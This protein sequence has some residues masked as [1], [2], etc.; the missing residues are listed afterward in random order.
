MEGS[1]IENFI[2]CRR[3]KLTD[4]FLGIQVRITSISHQTV[5]ENIF[6]LNICQKK[7]NKIYDY[8]IKGKTKQN[9]SI[10]AEA[11]FF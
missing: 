10:L 8:P 5:T 2:H 7:S 6:L 11:E 3:F 9:F 4:H 1:E